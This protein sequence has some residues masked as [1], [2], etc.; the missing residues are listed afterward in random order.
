MA[1]SYQIIS[2][3]LFVLFLKKRI[4][5]KQYITTAI[6]ISLESGSNL[7]TSA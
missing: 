5:A 3:S 6:L 7:S 1:N 4:A 2:I